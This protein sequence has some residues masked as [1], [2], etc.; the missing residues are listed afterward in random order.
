MFC[1]SRQNPRLFLHLQH[2]TTMTT[3]LRHV[4]IQGES[5]DGVFRI[6]IYGVCHPET[7]LLGSGF[8]LVV[9]GVCPPLDG[10]S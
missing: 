2:P 10:D 4:R 3:E 6:T 5:A 9:C 8:Q 7:S 1:S